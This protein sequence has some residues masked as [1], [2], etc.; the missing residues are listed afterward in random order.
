MKN[1]WYKIDDKIRFLL[2]GGFNFCVSYIIYSVV[3]I[4][5][6]TEFYQV[7]LALAWIFSSIVSFTTQKI[8][9][10]QGTDFWLKEYLK[11]CTTWF[12]SYLIN[13]IALEILVKIVHINVYLAQVFATAI[14]AV[15]TY[16]LFKQFAFKN[17]R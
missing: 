14:C 16:I 8:L 15:F 5:L 6:G 4:V 9:V 10:F 13:A 2:V 12:F 1:Y 11:C 17:Y 7:S 3:C